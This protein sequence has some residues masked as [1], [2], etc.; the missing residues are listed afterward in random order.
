MTMEFLSE[1]ILRSG[2]GEELRASIAGDKITIKVSGAR[3]HG[4]VA[5]VEYESVPD[6][7]GPPPHFHHAHEECFYVL[8]GEL[9]MLVGDRVLVAGP[10]DF[11]VAPRRTAH[12]FWNAR[13]EPCRFV[14]TFTPA[15]FEEVFRE[16]GRLIEA[17]APTEEL[18]ALPSQFG[19]EVIPWPAGTDPRE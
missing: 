8:Q 4:T 17:G 10:G 3:S 18:R 9:S 15:G 1:Y 19:T 7:P 16:F 11:A 12:T 14:A 2:G 13:D 6:A 5:F